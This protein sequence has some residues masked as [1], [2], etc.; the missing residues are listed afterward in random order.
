M[1]PSYTE[2]RQLLTAKDL[3]R[4]H[5]CHNDTCDNPPH[6]TQETVTQNTSRMLCSRRVRKLLREMDA[7]RVLHDANARCHHTPSCWPLT[8]TL[9][10]SN[11]NKTAAI[12][13][14]FKEA[15]R[16]HAACR[17]CRLDFPVTMA[18]TREV[19]T[20]QHGWT[21][22][23]N[24]FGVR[25]DG[26][27]PDNRNADI[28]TSQ[29]AKPAGWFDAF[30]QH[31]TQVHMGI[32]KGDAVWSGMGTVSAP[33]WSSLNAAPDIQKVTYG[34]GLEVLPTWRQYQSSAV[35]PTKTRPVRDWAG[36][37]EA[38]VVV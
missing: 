37:R 16:T 35:D 9:K 17:Q 28:W 22:T 36:W 15:M 32:K 33:W 27:I 14:H 8:S 30:H 7:Q 34:N 31:H 5:F 3:E 6:S 21:P 2:W 19:K 38:Y 24:E 10:A 1:R 4:S 25:S 23:Y 11:D 26:A 29:A 12:M 20:S 18:R 13:K